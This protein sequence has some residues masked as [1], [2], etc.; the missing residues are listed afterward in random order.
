MVLLANKV[1]G[2]RD[3]VPVIPNTIVVKPNTMTL[4]A[5]TATLFVNTN[6]LFA[7]TVSVL[8]N[9]VSVITNKTTVFANTVSVLINTELEKC[10][11]GQ[12]VSCSGTNRARMGQNRH[13]LEG[14]ISRCRHFLQT[15]TRATSPAS[16]SICDTSRN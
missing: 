5:N 16:S 7:N 3:T 9:T 10:L 15:S 1:F 6:V 14:R 13:H 2:F 11:L 4:L 12:K 8:A